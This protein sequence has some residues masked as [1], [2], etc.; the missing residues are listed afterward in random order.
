MPSDYPTELDTVAEATVRPHAF[1][2]VL[3]GILLF[4]ATV[5]GHPVLRGMQLHEPGD[6]PPWHACT[7]V[8]LRI[9]TAEGKVGECQIRG[10]AD[11]RLGVISYGIDPQH[12]RR[13]LGVAAVGELLAVARRMGIVRLKARV[14]PSNDISIRVLRSHGFERWSRPPGVGDKPVVFARW[15]T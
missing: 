2:Q 9:A 12:R 11:L 15:T 4:D 10:V 14:H 1:E 8:H 7:A 5:A 3:R 13:G 6:A